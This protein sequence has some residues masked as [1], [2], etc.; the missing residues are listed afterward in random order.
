[1]KILEAIKTESLMLSCGRKWIAITDDNMF[2]VYEKPYHSK[3]TQI[4]LQT[5]D[6][7]RAVEELLND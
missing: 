6:E 3:T 1:M 2:R 4:L 5:S 7:D